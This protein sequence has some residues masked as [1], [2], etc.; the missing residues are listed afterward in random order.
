MNMISKHDILTMTLSDGYQMHYRIWGPRE[1][2]DIIVMLHGGMSHSEWQSPLADEIRS[3]S[4]ITFVASDRRGCG[5][6]TENKGDLG[7]TELVID[8]VIQ[9]LNFFSKSFTR[10][11]LAGWCQGGQFASVAATMAE[12]KDSPYSLILVTPG[13]F[14][15]DQFSSRLDVARNIIFS[16]LEEFE[17]N[18]DPNRPFISVPMQ[19]SDFTSDNEWLSYIEGDTLKTT[20]VS[21]NTVAIMDAVM[22]QSAISIFEANMPILAILAENDR[23]VSNDKVKN[24]ISEFISSSPQNRLIFFQTAH[25][26]HFQKPVELAQE[27]TSFISSLK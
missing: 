9:Q 14:W 12:G 10:V 22:Q 1:G 6:N 21:L 19:H 5:L 15:S 2:E 20:K 3:L 11:H 24:H 7:S 23:I 18:P 8:D 16:F 25:A 27:I 4:E 13:F 26:I 17:L